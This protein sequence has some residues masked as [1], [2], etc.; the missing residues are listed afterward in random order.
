MN[1]P[2]PL[3]HSLQLLRHT[4]PPQAIIH[5]GAGRGQGDLHTWQNWEPEHALC[6]DADNDNI[7]HIQEKIAA[8]GGQTCCALLAG[9]AGER[10]YH[11]ASNPDENGLLPPLQLKPLWPNL[12]EIRQEKRQAITLDELLAKPEYQALAGQKHTWLIIDCL[13]AQEI[14]QGASQALKQADVVILRC[15]NQGNYPE[16]AQ[17]DYSQAQTQGTNFNLLAASFIE[18]NHPH[19]GYAILVRNTA[20]CREEARQ[21]EQSQQNQIAALTQQT[22]ALTQQVQSLQQEL[23]QTTQACDEQTRL[24]NE[25]QQNI[26]KITVNRENDAKTAA[27][28]RQA[29]DAHNQE[30][31][32]RQ[33]LMQEEL[34]KAEAQIELIKDLLL[35]EPGL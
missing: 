10:I 28:Q 24:A 19:A 14:L 31:Q 15:L 4:L 30:L 13:P 27:E 16:L 12:R 17:L 26:Q 8:H 9:Q 11:N 33:Q 18:G 34:L 1:Q 35:R 7:R 5:I 22:Q 20:Q 23:Q 2:S 6:I 32:H 3:A 25:R 29:M 21:H